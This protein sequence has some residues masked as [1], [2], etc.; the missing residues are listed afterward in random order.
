MADD[1]RSHQL[2]RA[3]TLLG[4]EHELRKKKRVLAALVV[5]DLRSPLSGALSHLDLI[6]AELADP[7]GIRPERLDALVADARELVQ[8]AIA[9]AAT[10]LDVDEL[11]DGMLRA[12]PQPMRLAETIDAAWK[13]SLANAKVR[14]LQWSQA[15]P[16]DLTAELDPDLFA[17]VL[18][19]LLDN[20]TRYASRGGRVE[21]GAELRGDVLELA[22]GNDGPAVPEAERESI[23]GRYHQMEQRRAHARANRGLGLY[24][25]RLAIEAHGGTITVEERGELRTTFVARIPQPPILPAK[26]D[27][28]RVRRPSDPDLERTPPPVAR[29]KPTTDPGP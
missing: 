7:A 5:H 17:R 4:H 19:N 24:F 15:I 20:A 6:K 3:A 27:E 26:P 8:R 14:D 11:E 29:P 22:I 21:A 18:E 13:T 25:C 16:T 28:A 2:R 12:R 9:L 1:A 23:F 10:I